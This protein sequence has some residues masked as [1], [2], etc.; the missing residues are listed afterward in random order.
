MTAIS[1][2]MKLPVPFLPELSTLKINIKHG[3]GYR[4]PKDKITYR[5]LLDIP[6]S[7]RATISW[8][9]IRLYGARIILRTTN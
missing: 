7:P 6:T 3:Y 4:T 9:H 8:V 5:Q 1:F 2:R